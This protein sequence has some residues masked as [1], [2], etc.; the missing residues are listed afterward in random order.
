MGLRNIIRKQKRLFAI[1]R[2]QAEFIVQESENSNRIRE[3]LKKTYGSQK[4]QVEYLL[5]NVFNYE[6]HGLKRNGFFVDLACA[7]GVNLNNTYFLER[8]LNWEGLLFE[9][10]PR[11]HNS[12]K[13][14]RTSPLITSCVTDRSGSEVDFRI[15]NLMLGGIV[16]EDF[17]NSEKVRG[18]QLV[19]AEIIKVPT[20]TLVEELDASKA[21]KIIDYLSLD[22]EGAE[23]LILK[24]FD[25]AKYKFRFMT[26]ER[27][28]LNL[29]LLLDSQGY[30]QVAHRQFDVFYAH[31]DF[32]SELNITPKFTFIQTPPKDW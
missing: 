5:L 2:A 23:E 14:F 4:G 24:K 19:S 30:V 1:K 16:G 22:V 9:P 28:T 32:L 6:V 29:D 31:R 18:R 27:P 13:K 3:N 12:I 7:N 25:F 26:I 8:H 21:P 17:D 10:N 11:F 15:D 20:T